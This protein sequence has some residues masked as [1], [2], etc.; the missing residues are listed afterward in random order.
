MSLV[1]QVASIPLPEASLKDAETSLYSALSVRQFGVQAAELGRALERER[2]ADILTR[3]GFK[4][5]DNREVY[6]LL[7]EVCAEILG[8][9]KPEE[10]A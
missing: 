3:W 2:C 10:A 8:N 6:E 5:K 4:N 1:Y 9:T 7:S